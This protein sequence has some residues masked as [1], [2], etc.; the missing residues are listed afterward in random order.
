MTAFRE[1]VH[2]VKVDGHIARVHVPVDVGRAAAG[3]AAARISK[4]VGRCRR[5]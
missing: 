5:R 2:S 3:A 4:E 1:G